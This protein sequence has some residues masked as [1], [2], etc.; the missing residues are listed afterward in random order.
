MLRGLAIGAVL[1]ITVLTLAACQGELGPA[2]QQGPIGPTGQPGPKGE[3]GPQGLVGLQGPQG[4]QGLQG[5]QGVAGSQGLVGPQG[6]GI[7]PDETKALI[8]KAVAAYVPSSQPGDPAVIARGGQLYDNWMAEIGGAA[9]TGN[10][11]LWALQ[12]TN[13]R[14]GTVTY[15]CKECHGWDYKGA[16]GAYSSGSRKTGFSGVYRASQV[17]TKDQLIAI[18]K[19]GTDYRHDFST[20]LSDAQLGELATF[21]KSG[22]FNMVP[23]V[24][25]A[26]RKPKGTVNV[27]NGQTRYGRTCANCHGDDG[28]KLNFGTDA[29]PEYVGTVAVNNPWEFMHKAMNG[30]PGPDA[31]DMPPVITRGWITQ[32]VLDVLAYSQTLPVK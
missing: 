9:P 19:G 30:Q 1:A 14:T 23:Y 28:K 7:P 16:G 11:P 15:R 26:T 32:D 2:G 12:T 3:Q 25:Y 10:Q 17:M 6:P 13:T 20:S 31:E 4:L 21:L 5:P 29:A 24:D 22:V 18:L 8:D 27:S